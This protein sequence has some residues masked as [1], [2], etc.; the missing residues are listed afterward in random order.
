MVQRSKDEDIYESTKESVKKIFDNL[1]SYIEGKGLFFINYLVEDRRALFEF[2]KRPE[3]KTIYV[4]AIE[5]I[6]Y[7]NQKAIGDIYFYEFHLSN[8]NAGALKRGIGRSIGSID[9]S[10]SRVVGYYGIKHIDKYLEDEL[11][12]IINSSN[13]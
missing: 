1:K 13:L 6:R 4:I 12:D 7:D 10:K 9:I 5:R 3:D 2:S 11:K 8:I